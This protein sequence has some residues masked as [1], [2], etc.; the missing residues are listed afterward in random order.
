MEP[1]LI[2]FHGKITTLTLPSQRRR[3]SLSRRVKS[4]GAKVTK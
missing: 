3:P 1:D 2:L 4:Q